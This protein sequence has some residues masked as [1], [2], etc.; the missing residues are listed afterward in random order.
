MLSSPFQ[1][2]SPAPEWQEHEPKEYIPR[3]KRTY[4]P[5]I[6][7]LHLFHLSH[8]TVCLYLSVRSTMWCKWELPPWR[9][10]TTSPNSKEVWWLDSIREWNQFKVADFLYRR[11]EMSQGNINQLLE[12]WDHS[13]AKYGGSGPFASYKHIYNTINA[14]EDGR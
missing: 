1:S 8:E 7:S 9:N 11:E 12:L 5:F 3:L 10:P 4:H 14:I 2:P 6:N 13:L